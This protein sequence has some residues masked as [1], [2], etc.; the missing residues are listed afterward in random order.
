[1]AAVKQNGEALLYASADLKNDP[2]IVAAAITSEPYPCR[3][4]TRPSYG[5]DYCGQQLKDLIKGTLLALKEHGVED[6]SDHP[7]FADTATI[8]KYAQQWKKK[9]C[10]RIWLLTEQVKPLPEVV[11]QHILGLAGVQAEYLSACDLIHCAPVIAADLNLESPKTIELLQE[12]QAPK[13]C[14]LFYGREDHS[15]GNSDSSSSS[16]SASSDDDNL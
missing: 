1:M 2:D 16:E 13:R 8:V 11:K 3:D 9:L 4:W 12:A 5:M 14:R 7:D 6:P 10:E 15:E